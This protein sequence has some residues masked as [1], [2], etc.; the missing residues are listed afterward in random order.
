MDVLAYDTHTDV[1]GYAVVALGW[2]GIRT[3]VPR[4]L[5]V[6]AEEEEIKWTPEALVRLGAVGDGPLYGTDVAK[7]APA[8]VSGF[9]DCVAKARL[10]PE[11]FLEQTKCS[12]KGPVARLR[13]YAAAANGATLFVRARH[14]DAD[15]TAVIPLAIS[16][17]GRKVAAIELR[18]EEMHE[19]RVSVG[20]EAFPPGKHTVEL[21]LGKPG[22]FEIDH[23]LVLAK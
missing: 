5:R 22:A 21:R 3:A 2:M 1:R 14:L 15:K 8:M 23:F 13:F 12:S 6:L 16:V 11:E 9:G 4:L 19:A 17:D 7:G 10:L 18:G 20:P